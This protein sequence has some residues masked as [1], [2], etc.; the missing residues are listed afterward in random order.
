MVYITIGPDPGPLFKHSAFALTSIVACFPFI[1]AMLDDGFEFTPNSLC[2]DERSLLA[3][4]SYVATS[5]HYQTKPAT[6]HTP[7]DPFAGP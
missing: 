3:P 1:H 5:Q 4:D 6:Q 7:K 2:P